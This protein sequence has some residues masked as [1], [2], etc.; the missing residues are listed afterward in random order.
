VFA[1]AERIW[2]SRFVLPSYSIHHAL[3]GRKGEE[4]GERG[5]GKLRQCL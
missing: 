2:K 1:S 5:S 4:R 3:L